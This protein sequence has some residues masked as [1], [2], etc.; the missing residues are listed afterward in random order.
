MAE[1]SLN[2]HKVY[3]T[4]GPGGGK[5]T[6]SR[7]LAAAL[8]TPLCE[9]DAMML[10]GEARG[11]PYDVLIREVVHRVLELDAWVA[12]GAYLGWVD[13]LLRQADLVV[14]LDVPW[15]IASYRILSRHVKKE[16][17]RN[18]PF[19]GWPRLLRFWRWSR[20]YYKNENPPGLR[21]GVPDTRDTAIE[22]LAPYKDK[23]VVCRTVKDAVA[24]LTPSR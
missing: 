5:T 19:P 1:L 8:G 15:R 10:D 17:R 11:V 4:G 12:E 9:L 20:G 13:L 14:W 2:S 3:V 16:L 21:L 6:L 22:I 18:N 24:L 7:D 23:L